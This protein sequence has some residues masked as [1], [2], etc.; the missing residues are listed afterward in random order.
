MSNIS[1]NC[2][3]VNLTIRTWLAN[4]QDSGVA[5]EVA[6]AKG[7]EDV[8]MG[9]YWKSLLP[10]CAEVDRINQVIS[11][12]R[13]F[14]YANSLAYMHD[15]PRILPTSHYEV[16]KNTMAELR[17]QFDIAVLA[18]IA[19]YDSLKL[20]AKKSMGSLYN[21]LDYPDKDYV[22]TRYGIETII[23][24]LPVTDS[25]LELGFDA[26][27]AAEMKD[28]VEAELS[29]RFRKNAHALWE[30]LSKNVEGLLKTL[31]DPKKAIQN[32]TLDV[33]RRLGQ[34]LP[35]LNVLEDHRLDTVCQRMLEI[36]DGVS[37][38]T[39]STDIPRRDKVAADLRILRSAITASM[40]ARSSVIDDVADG[41]MEPLRVAA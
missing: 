28:R 14:H 1:K 2:V 41:A 11:Q 35:K 38:T 20:D 4:K 36:L 9:R 34:L 18:L 25:L 8:K 31:G 3:L 40:A 30:Q 10:K 17:A 5:A 6:Q 37:H 19:K 29:D 32:R 27:A 39:L 33:S 23:L 26:A 16:Y 24:P 13:D 12:T 21:E 7:V 15:G 22:R